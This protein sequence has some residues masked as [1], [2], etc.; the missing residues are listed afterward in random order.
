VTARAA[1]LALAAEVVDDLHGHEQRDIGTLD[2]RWP[3]R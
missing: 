3:P 2:Q 1:L